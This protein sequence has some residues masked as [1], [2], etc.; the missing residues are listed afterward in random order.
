MSETEP[1]KD[2]EK[3]PVFFDVDDDFEY[4]VIKEEIEKNKEETMLPAETMP[5]TKPEETLIEKKKTKKEKEKVETTEEKTEKRGKKKHNEGRK[6]IEEEKGLEIPKSM[7]LEEKLHELFDSNK[8][9]F[10]RTTKQL[11]GDRTY[12]FLPNGEKQ[13]VS[14]KNFDN[15]KGYWRA[16]RVFYKEDGSTEEKVVALNKVTYKEWKKVEDDKLPEQN[17]D[18]IYRTGE[19]KFREAKV[20][21]AKGEIECSLEIDDIGGKIEATFDKNRLLTYMDKEGNVAYS[22]A[23]ASRREYFEIKK[24]AKLKPTIDAIKQKKAEVENLEN[25]LNQIREEHD[26]KYNTVDAKGVWNGLKIVGGWFPHA[27]TLGKITPKTL[28]EFWTESKDYKEKYAQKEQQQAD[29]QQE[30][31]DL[32]NSFQPKSETERKEDETREFLRQLED[33]DGAKP[34]LETEVE[35]DELSLFKPTKEEPETIK[36]EPVE[37]DPKEDKD[38]ELKRLLRIEEDT[39]K[40]ETGK[41]K[42]YYYEAMDSAGAEIKDSIEAASEE[43]AQAYIRKMGHFTTKFEE[44]EEKKWWQFWK[45]GS[46]QKEQ[47][48]QEGESEFMKSYKKSVEDFDKKKKEKKESNEI[49][50]EKLAEQIKNAKT[51]GEVI[52]VLKGMSRLN[53]VIIVRGHKESIADE[54]IINPNYW[55]SN[56]EYYLR[57]TDDNDDD[58]WENDTNAY[59]LLGKEVADKMDELYEKYK[60]LGSRIKEKQKED[61]AKSESKEEE[62]KTITRADLDREFEIFHSKGYYDTLLGEEKVPPKDNPYNLVLVNNGFQERDKI[63]FC[64]GSST[65]EYEGVIVRNPKGNLLIETDVAVNNVGEIIFLENS[66]VRK[67]ESLSKQKIEI[68]DEPVQLFPETEPVSETKPKEEEEKNIL[69]VSDLDNI[70][71]RF[72][73]KAS[74]QFVYNNELLDRNGFKEG[75][76]VLFSVVGKEREGIVAKSVLGNL[77]IREKDAGPYDVDI[78]LSEGGYIKKKP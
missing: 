11:S 12:Y 40:P 21:S 54:N 55:L 67:K 15:S 57:D 39:K 75:D 6:P 9:E 28:K 19:G 63:V 13:Y 1:K 71:D 43:E 69:T 3:E 32:K 72:D 73:G 10:E 77:F 66:Y 68:S 14:L 36:G 33:A 52:E 37:E 34:V 70:V 4:P 50:P 56:I 17:K 23:Q 76:D 48:Q 20:K 2:S 26:E 45:E 31:H 61:E 60:K 64:I 38:R 49:K 35:K 7:S 25:N 18:I 65:K 16:T 58:I 47:K 5:P 78:I 44:V 41:G 42:R 8:K 74:S 51:I 59:W 46:K 29:L 24:Q 53:Q 30:I 22:T 27:L 62:V